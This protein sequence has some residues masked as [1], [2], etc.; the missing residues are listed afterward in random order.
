MRPF[1][2]LSPGHPSV[3]EACAACSVA[4]VAGDWQAL[5]PLGPGPFP[6]AQRL[7]REC[8]PYA[9][10]CALVHWTCATGWPN[11]DQPQGWPNE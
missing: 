8:R 3:G 10:V 6:E 7:R 11:P 1:G 5:I 4:F 2:P 9:A